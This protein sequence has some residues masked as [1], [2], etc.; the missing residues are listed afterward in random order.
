M[1]R[2]ILA[3]R[4]IADRKEEKELDLPA[5]G[6]CTLLSTTVTL[7]K[8]RQRRKGESLAEDT[9]KS[10]PTCP[11]DASAGIGQQLSARDQSALADPAKN[12]PSG[13]QR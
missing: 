6:R 7:K 9:A 8:L 5:L 11:P 10:V 3:I 1:K 12:I 4:V 13:S 2:K